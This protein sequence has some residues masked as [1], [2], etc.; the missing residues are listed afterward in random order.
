MTKENFAVLWKQAISEIKT[1]IPENK[2]ETFNNYVTNFE[3]KHNFV[4]ALSNQDKGAK[5]KKKKIPKDLEKRLLET[6]EVIPVEYNVD[7]ET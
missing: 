7:E 6:F 4:C 2:I 5:I 3:K 1:F